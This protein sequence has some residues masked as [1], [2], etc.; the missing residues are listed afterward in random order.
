MTVTIKN[1]VDLRNQFGV[2]ETKKGERKPYSAIQIG[3]KLHS[4]VFEMINSNEEIENGLLIPC[5]E[6]S[7]L[8]CIFALKSCLNKN[9]IFE[10]TGT[11]G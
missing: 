4:K 10:Y 7:E 8:D 6:F 1:F 3:K 2:E 9:F 11:I 5:G